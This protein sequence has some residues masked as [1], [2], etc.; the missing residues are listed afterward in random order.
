MSLKTNLALLLMASAVFPAFA[1]NAILIIPT[2]K[3]VKMNEQFSVA[4]S[5]NPT[6]GYSWIVRHLPEQVALTGMD[7]AQSPD[8]KEGMTGCGGTKTLYFKAVKK[9]HGKLQLQYARPF[10]VLSNKTQ[11]INIEVTK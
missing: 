9:G 8:C 11:T 4:L 5:S 7:Y 1:G 10:E 2:E 3:T 6:T